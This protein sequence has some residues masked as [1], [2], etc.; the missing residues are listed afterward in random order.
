MSRFNYFYV[1]FLFSFP[2]ITLTNKHF[3]LTSTNYFDHIH[4]N[5]NFHIKI[6]SI[7]YFYNKYNCTFVPQHPDVTLNSCSNR[8]SCILDLKPFLFFHIRHYITECRS[9][10][11]YMCQRDIS[12]NTEL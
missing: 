6:N 8:S 10:K 7:K 9:I 5:H 11:L 2:S 1:L 4:C 3:L 12:I